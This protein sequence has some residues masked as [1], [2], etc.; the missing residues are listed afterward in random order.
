VTGAGEYWVSLFDGYASTTGLVIIAL[1]EI[2]S[3]MYIYGHERL[4]ADIEY[5]T[6][7]YP[8]WY[9]QLTWRIIGPG[10]LVL[11]LVG[12]FVE[13]VMNPAMYDAW[14]KEVGETRKLPFPDWCMG[15]ALALIILGIVPIIAGWLMN[16]FN[17]SG[18]SG[19][20]GSASTTMRRI[21]TAASTRPMM[22]DYEVRFGVPERPWYRR[23]FT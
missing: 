21:D 4:S 19:R 18:P 20:Q 12:S 23:W 3:V 6:G 22:E 15:I 2:V 8:G 16:K 10:F 7:Y 9:W 14:D 11:L 13:Q 5:M 17:V 1:L